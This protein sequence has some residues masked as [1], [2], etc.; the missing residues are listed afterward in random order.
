MR[1]LRYL[2]RQRPRLDAVRAEA[3]LDLRDGLLE[4]RADRIA[5]LEALLARE[6]TEKAQLMAELATY[7]THDFM[8]QALRLRRRQAEQATSVRAGVGHHRA[9]PATDFHPRVRRTP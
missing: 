2:K 3:Q 6:R 4:A 8:R 7:K 9:A 1:L 5:E